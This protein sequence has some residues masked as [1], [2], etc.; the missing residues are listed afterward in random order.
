MCGRFTLRTPLTVLVDQ[1]HFDIGNAQLSLRY[2]IAPTQDVAAV[3]LV[4]GKRELA[5]L[6]WG[7]VPSWAKDVKIG[8]SGIN[9]RA[10][11]VAT[12]PMFR[13]AYKRRRCLVLADGYYEWLRVGKS[14]QPYLYEIDGGK[15]FAFAGL[16]EQWW[17]TGSPPLHRLR[18]GIR[19]ID[20]GSGGG[21][22]SRPK[23]DKEA[24]T[25][26]SCTLITTDAN[27]LAAKVH[28]RMPVILEPVNYDAWL[29][30]TKT[31]VA[32]MLAQFPADRMTARPVSTHVNNARNE[33]PECITP[34][35]E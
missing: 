13:A 6:R 23:R 32:Y 2:N 34:P 35:D 33:G 12:K 9:A 10:D 14:K 24:P 7:L 8:A 17:G 31:D 18:S 25:L 22:I 3:R 29:D 4:D 20:I 15:P 5:L 1:F 11:T 21:R 19:F 30:P 26:E 27:E 16:W 28:D